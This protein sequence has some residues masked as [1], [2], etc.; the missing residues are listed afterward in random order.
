MRTKAVLESVLTGFITAMLSHRSLITPVTLAA[1]KIE[2]RHPNSPL[3]S[4][5]SWYA[6][7]SVICASIALAVF[8]SRIV[9]KHVTQ[10]PQRQPDDLHDDSE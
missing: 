9:Y 10:S 1:L 3:L 7:P 4:M 2:R 5:L 8:A 6:L